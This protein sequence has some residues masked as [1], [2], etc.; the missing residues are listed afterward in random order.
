MLDIFVTDCVLNKGTDSKEIQLLNMLAILVT[1]AVLNKG[2]DSK[3]AQLL[4][5]LDVSVIVELLF[6]VKFFNLIQNANKLA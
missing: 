6:T 2:T 1:D 5:M 3:D 4:N